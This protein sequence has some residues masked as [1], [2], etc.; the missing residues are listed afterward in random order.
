MFRP[1]TNKKGTIIDVSFVDIGL[2]FRA[3]RISESLERISAEVTVSM[4]ITS[5]RGVR[6][7]R[8]LWSRASLLDDRSKD[9]FVQSLE[10][11]TEDKSLRPISYDEVTSE[12]FGCII[13]A[14]REGDL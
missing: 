10:H 2:Y 4:D 3:E 11:A 12:A 7:E 13:S 5:D 9:A 8:I 6:R 14:H 1:T